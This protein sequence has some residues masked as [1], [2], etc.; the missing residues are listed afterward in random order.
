M[1]DEIIPIPSIQ[2]GVQ[3]GIPSPKDGMRGPGFSMERTTS[4][5]GDR[6]C[7]VVGSCGQLLSGRLLWQ[8]LCLPYAWNGHGL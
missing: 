1:L 5:S 4:C 6:I 3:P 8:K 2:T 7:F